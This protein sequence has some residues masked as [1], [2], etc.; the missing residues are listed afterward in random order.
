M[1]GGEDLGGGFI[2]APRPRGFGRLKEQ[3]PNTGG[4]RREET[5]GRGGVGEQGG[6]ARGRPGAD[7]SR[8]GRAEG[9]R[10]R[11]VEGG[12]QGGGLPPHVRNRLRDEKSKKIVS[13]NFDKFAEIPEVKNLHAWM[14]EQQLL[15]QEMQE[16]EKGIDWIDRNPYAK[17]FYLHMNEEQGAVWLME[18][19]GEVGR[20]WIN[21]EGGGSNQDNGKVG[22]RA[23]LEGGGDKGDQPQHPKGGCGRGVS[24]VWAGEGTEVCTNGWNK[25]Q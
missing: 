5:G 19:Y 22:G 7:G 23:N 12:R 9:G 25:V 17:K 16:Q 10:Q 15:G 11:G 8:Q 20:D 1:S 3:P 4:T 18:K 13:F 24:E 2:P 6:G 14:K 21:E